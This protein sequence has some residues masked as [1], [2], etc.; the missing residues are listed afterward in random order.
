MLGSYNAC[1]GLNI[2]HPFKTRRNSRILSGGYDGPE[3]LTLPC[4]TY[5]GMFFHKSL[6]NRIG[7]PLRDYFIYCD[8]FEWS[9]RIIQK[10]GKI[11]LVKAS[12]VK[13]IESNGS[14][15]DNK[16]YYQAR[17]FIRFQKKLAKNKFI[18]YLNAFCYMMLKPTL[19]KAIWDGI[20]SEG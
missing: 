20:K 8:D 2:F 18:F 10:G 5:G 11:Y 7:L 9:H 6:I 19:Q 15:S 13:D 14:G 3:H 16:E 12:R 4:A 1:L 17:N